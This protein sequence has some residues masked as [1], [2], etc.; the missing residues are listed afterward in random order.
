MDR[1]TS[2]SRK[3]SAPPGLPGRALS[4]VLYLSSCTVFSTIS[5]TYQTIARTV[6]TTFGSGYFLNIVKTAHRLHHAASGGVRSITHAPLNLQEYSSTPIKTSGCRALAHPTARNSMFKPGPLP[7]KAHTLHPHSTHH[8]RIVKNKLKNKS[9]CE[10]RKN[11][12][13][14]ALSAAWPA[15]SSG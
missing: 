5:S 12:K 1:L 3:N 10:C 8:P 11:I 9:I 14:R 6:T 2:G 15:E 7:G 13:H 4:L